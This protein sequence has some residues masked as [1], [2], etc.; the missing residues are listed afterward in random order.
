MIDE[1]A[2]TFDHL[3]LLLVCIGRLVLGEPQ[4]LL[5]VLQQLHQL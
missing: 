5:G 3:F 1:H 2:Q 4:Q